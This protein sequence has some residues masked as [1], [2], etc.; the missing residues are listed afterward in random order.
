MKKY[1]HK[2][3]MIPLAGIILTGLVLFLYFKGFRITY[4]PELENSWGAI[5]AFASWAGVVASAAAIL[6][7]IRIPSVIADRQ[8][9]I[10]LF[11]KRFEVY[12]VVRK[13]I[14]FARM[15]EN[16]VTHE[17]IQIYFITSFGHEMMRDNY[18]ETL[19]RDSIHHLHQ[20]V[21]T[22][23]KGEFLFDEEVKADLDRLSNA[24]L[25]IMGIKETHPNFRKVFEEYQTTVSDMQKS[26]VPAM[27]VS[28]KLK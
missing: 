18:R 2:K 21:Q 19:D 8:N 26:M 9:K 24:L 14:G 22:M 28:L 7:A 16:S 10:A 11:E 20:A 4:A 17:E 25:R 27:E 23:I 3:Y 5:S 13:S 15:I 12:D 1:I 6:V